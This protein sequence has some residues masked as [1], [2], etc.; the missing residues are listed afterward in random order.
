M[1]AALSNGDR[2][3]LGALVTCLI[4]SLG[5][6]VALAV[7]LGSVPPGWQSPFGFSVASTPMFRAFS[8]L[9]AQA[10]SPGGFSRAVTA[11]LV[12]LFAI[13][14]GAI[15]A[16]GGISTAAARQRAKW[17]V[18]AGGAAMLA[19]VVLWVPPVLSADLYRQAIYGHMVTHGLNPYALPAAASGADRLLALADFRQLTS[20]Y[21]PAYTWLSALAMALAPATP[22]GV[23]L[24]WKTMSALAA[25]GCVALAG[26][27]TRALAGGE[28]DGV[29]AQLWLAW[30]PVVVI[31]AAASGH[32]E[33]IMMLPALGGILLLQ[34][35]RSVPGVLL[36]V[37]STLTKWV[38]GALLLLAVVREVRA[39]R[40][41]RRLPTLLGLAGSGAL[42]AAILYVPFA[43]G[44]ATFGGI[45][46]ILVRGA[47]AMGSG[48][49][50]WPPE[51]VR[52]SA[53]AALT[54]VAAGF[55]APDGARLVATA[56]AL[57]LVFILIIS[58]WLLPWY[59]MTP[60]VLAAV[61]PA[62]TN[63]LLLRI[64]SVGL[65]AGFMLYYR[66]LI[67]FARG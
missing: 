8:G 60:I 40:P 38:T 11:V 42:L 25:L 58:P 37:V 46:D 49:Q 53:F 47:D 64:S 26:P 6:D 39:A 10:L 56:T 18:G 35:R 30:N 15:V 66:E 44:L 31:E 62:G 23:A 43:R 65:A 33:P 55:A 48:G 61:L 28:G 41:G 36:L 45:H 29:D 3:R 2:L 34:R 22:L 57:I 12:L 63:R 32:I 54:L 50:A 16:I 1:P 52:L 19:L 4:A 21:G 9:P 13:W 7:V 24:A 14:G 27:V 20:S 17:I 67:P 59:F 51:W 5:L